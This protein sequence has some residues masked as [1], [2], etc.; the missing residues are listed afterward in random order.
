MKIGI[1][2]VGLLGSSL[3]VALKNKLQDKIEI[4]A[5]SSESTLEKARAMNLF[6]GFHSYNEIST[7]IDGL[8]LLFLCSPIKV[9]LEHIERI[10]E[11]PALSKPII[12]TDVG[13]TKRLIMEKAEKCFAQRKDIIFIG[14][15]PMAG[16]EFKGIDANDKSLYENAIY[17][18]TPTP[19]TEDEHV[20]KLLDIVK[21][22]GAIP[23]ILDPIKHD[24]AVAG[25]SHLPQMMASG[26]VDMISKE[27]NAELSKT[28]SAGG[29]RDMT[30]IASSQY[31]MWE[32][33]VETNKDNIFDLIDAY[34]T[35]LTFIKDSIKNKSLDGIFENARN[36]RD[37]IQ[38]GKKG[39]LQQQ[40]FEIFVRIPD[41]PGMILK[42]STIVAEENLNIKDISIQQSREQDGGQFRLGFA[43]LADSE[44]AVECLT[45]QGYFAKTIE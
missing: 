29:F 1:V 37:L 19:Q 31:R 10:S 25:I 27:D 11:A 35:E 36:T 2:G 32:D 9:I 7:A 43:T 34:I 8:D 28:L 26:L 5:F 42:I 12:I 41:E 40:L 20:S 3:A 18:V 22:V 13:S 33:I 17:V 15:H 30:R 4:T 21:L 45:K 16:N 14:G 24:R 6:A 23:L 44:K 39:L 38:K